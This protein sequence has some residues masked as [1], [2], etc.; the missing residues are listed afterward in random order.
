MFGYA[1]T[2]E[3]PHITS[4]TWIPL[5]LVVQT[6][7]LPGKC[8]SFVDICTMLWRHST[9]LYTLVL[10][11]LKLV[12]HGPIPV[13]DNRV[14]VGGHWGFLDTYK[15]DFDIPMPERGFAIAYLSRELT[16]YFFTFPVLKHFSQDRIVTIIDKPHILK[17]TPFA[18]TDIFIW[19][20]RSVLAH[21]V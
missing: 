9:V 4:V 8:G 19:K 16:Q 2:L 7:E 11:S 3:L 5:E 14:W 15:V 12:A 1:S 20:V 17:R 10:A 13:L 6:W 21:T 18:H